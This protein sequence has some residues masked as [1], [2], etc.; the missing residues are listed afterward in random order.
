MTNKYRQCSRE[1]HP[2]LYTSNSF[3]LS[4]QEEPQFQTNK[5]KDDKLF[6]CRHLSTNTSLRLYQQ[7]ILLASVLLSTSIY[8]QTNEL[9][10]SSLTIYLPRNPTNLTTSTTLD[11][12]NLYS[13]YPSHLAAFFKSLYLYYLHIYTYSIYY[14][15][16]TLIYKLTAAYLYKN[17]NKNIYINEN[18]ASCTLLLTTKHPLKIQT[19][20]KEE[21]TTVTFENVA[22]RILNIN[23]SIVAFPPL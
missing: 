15:V 17:K 7:P 11:S 2:S 18:S 9:P 14:N 21:N 3:H 6:S 4:G 13:Y 5:Q 19:R 22:E 1:Q 23:S 16:N 8:Y 12:T 10:N 20:K